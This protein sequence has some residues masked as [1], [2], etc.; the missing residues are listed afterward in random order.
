MKKMTSLLIGFISTVCVLAQTPDYLSQQQRSRQVDTDVTTEVKDNFLILYTHGDLGG[1]NVELRDNFNALGEPQAVGAGWILAKNIKSDTY[2][3]ALM[4]METAAEGSVIMKLPI[5][6]PL[7]SLSLYLNINGVD[8]VITVDLTNV[9]TGNKNINQSK[10][11]VYP[12]PVKD[13]LFVRL[14]PDLITNCILQL[15]NMEGKTMQS[16][17]IQNPNGNIMMPISVPNGMYTLIIRKE[18][19]KAEMYKGKIIVVQ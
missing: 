8:K 13:K 12:N 2:K 6:I 10:F 1:L 3:L 18:Q 15:I 5:L 9:S 19:E 11:F 14:T 7:K 16:I 4:I 17:K